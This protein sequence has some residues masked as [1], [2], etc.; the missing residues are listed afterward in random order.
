MC[1]NPELPVAALNKTNANCMSQNCTYVQACSSASQAKCFNFNTGAAVIST[2]VP[3][4]AIAPA[5]C[6]VLAGLRGPRSSRIVG[7]ASTKACGSGDPTRFLQDLDAWT[8][9]IAKN[10]AVVFYVIAAIEIIVMLAGCYLVCCASRET[11]AKFTG[12]NV[13]EA[14]ED[15]KA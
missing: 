15:W 14:D 7:M 2:A 13:D 10:A 12:F 11:V 5:I 4:Y 9:A 1:T 3:P 6:D 8:S